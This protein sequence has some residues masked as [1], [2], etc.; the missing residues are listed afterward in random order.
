MS[1]ALE[2]PERTEPSVPVWDRLERALSPTEAR[3]RVVSGIEVAHHT[4]RSGR[5]YVVI[6]NA[7]AQTYLKLDPRELELVLLMDGTRT[8][9]S[10][11][12]TYYRRNG[13]LALS[14]VAGL[15]EVLRTHRFLEEQPLDTYA[16]L[17]HALASRRPVRVVTHVVHRLLQPE[18]SVRSIDARLSDWYH[19]WGR[20]FFTKPA[21]LAG[22]V[23]GLAAPVFFLLELSRPRYALFRTGG[24]YLTGVLV[25]AALEAVTLALHEIGH[26]LAVKHAGRTVGRAGMMLYF[27]LPVAFIDT[28]VKIKNPEAIA[29]SHH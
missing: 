15:V 27:G 3:P 20:W 13:V 6:R 10:L 26:G 8:V 18:V 1:P 5:P 22:I 17:S 21:A 24:S 4:T 14:R 7:V 23:L 11:V 25:L 9:R 16:E 12:V 28:T 19:S 2:V 29:T